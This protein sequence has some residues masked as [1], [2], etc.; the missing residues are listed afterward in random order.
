MPS[1][2][3]YQ[4][5]L[6]I[7]IVLIILFVSSGTVYLTLENAK[8]AR[9]LIQ[10]TIYKQEQS[11]K[12]K[13]VKNL[14]Y[15]GDE[16]NRTIYHN[17]KHGYQFQ[18]PSDWKITTSDDL[19]VYIEDAR[20]AKFVFS[21]PALGGGFC[22][23]DTAYETSTITLT[24]QVTAQKSFCTEGATVTFKK[25]DREGLITL[26]YPG[27]ISSI[28]YPTLFDEILETVAFE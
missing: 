19:Y 20:G 21:L 28:H 25:D 17:Q 3:T 13:K 22:H 26:T 4:A 8:T 10:D 23:P 5:V 24:S 27:Q 9:L 18:Y 7:F 14:S 1:Y 11:I 2:K 16:E 6:P 15:L 12:I